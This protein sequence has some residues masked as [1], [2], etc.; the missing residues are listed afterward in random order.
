[1][2]PCKHWGTLSGSSYLVCKDCKAFMWALRE[3]KIEWIKER[4]EKIGEHK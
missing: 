3:F 1:M 4:L 2:K